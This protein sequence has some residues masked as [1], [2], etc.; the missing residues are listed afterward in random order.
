MRGSRTGTSRPARRCLATENAARSSAVAG[1]PWRS[2]YAGAPHT[3]ICTGNSW[4]PIYGDNIPSE[5]KPDNPGLDNWRVR[6]A[7]A[8]LW[9]DAVNR[10]GGDARLV[11]MPEF[12]I[13]G[14]THSPFADLN[15]V[16]VANLMSAF[17]AAKWLDTQGVSR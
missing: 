13:R 4:R 5:P 15:N 12:G 17:L 2:K 3:I 1:T 8:R 6:L 9:V 14:N 11:A 10:H 7:M 16:E